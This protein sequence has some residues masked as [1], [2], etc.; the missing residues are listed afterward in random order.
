MHD[1]QATLADYVADSW[2]DILDTCTR[3]G[4]CV[5][6]CPVVPHAPG[7]SDAPAGDVVAGVLSFI[8]EPGQA[9][10]QHSK[11]WMAQ[12]NGC[13]ECIPACPVGINPRRMVML[14]NAQVSK[15]EQPTPYLFQKMARSIRIL[16]GMQ[17]IP[18]DAARLLRPAR[19]RDVDIVFYTGCNPV[20]NPNLLFNSMM[21]LDALKVNYEVMGGPAAC[22]GI[23]HSKW[24]GDLPKGGKMS[25]ATL[26]RFGQFKPEK[27]LNWCPSCE[28]HLGETIKGYRE[29]QFEFGHITRFLMERKADLKKLFAHAVRKR[30]LVHTHQ[31]MPEVGKDVVE[32]LKAVPGLEIVHEVEE[33]AYMCGA[34]GSERAPELKTHGRAKTLEFAKAAE[35]DVVISLYHACHRQLKAAGLQHGF[36]VVNFT[37]ILVRALG[38]EPYEDTFERF[39]GRNDWRQVVKESEALMAANGIDMDPERLA[40]VLPEIVA[41]TEWKGGL[42]SFAPSA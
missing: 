23:V 24:E 27:V 5:E 29:V 28:I 35:V 18:E 31:G 34:S 37:E 14:A 20:R 8:R 33:P 16:A 15:I 19:P 4:K 36:E 26:V 22:C 12:C 40:E 1:N 32:L 3:C 38:E 9:V 13:G 10:A 2:N 7:L 42:C 11:T 17:M 30:V 39:L 6:V 41:A 25:E 21:L